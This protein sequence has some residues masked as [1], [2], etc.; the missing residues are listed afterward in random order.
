[1]G[2]AVWAIASRALDSPLF[3]SPVDIVASGVELARSG[4]L[5]GDIATSLRRIAIGFALG[6]LVGVPLGLAMGLFR[7]VRAFCDPVVQFLRFVPS[8]AWLIP[9]IMWFG[10]GETSKIVI[11]FYMTVF[12]VLLNTMAGV[13]AIPRNHLRSA[14]NYEL[15]GWQLFAWIVFPATMSYSVAGARIAM[16]N[17]FA[18]VV[19]AE[20][21]AAD[22]GLGYRIVESGKWTA[23]GDMFAAMLVLGLLGIVAD[24]LVR[25]ATERYLHRYLPVGDHAA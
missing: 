15:T 2:I 12:L 21:I 13:A 16:G 3:P 11:I 17:S 4:V 22:A 25:F 24:R 20:L 9:A 18:A 14:E 7:W 6:C 5:L 23:M 1:L 10:I 19:G 8:I